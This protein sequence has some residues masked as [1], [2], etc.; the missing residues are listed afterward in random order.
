MKKLSFLALAGLLA[1][2]SC[3]SGT[4][5]SAAVPYSAVGTWDIRVLPIGQTQVLNDG[6]AVW[7]S[8]G[9][10]GELDGSWYDLDSTYLGR[11]VGNAKAGTV[12]LTTGNSFISVTDGAFSD[13]S[14][15]GHYEAGSYGLP[16]NAKGQFQMTRR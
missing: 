13:N 6:Y 9:D 10:K 4:S 15:K 14:F 8:Q 3:G 12:K 2:V 5:Q 11:A 16:D 7:I 1:L